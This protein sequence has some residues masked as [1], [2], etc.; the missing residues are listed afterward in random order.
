MADQAD[1]LIDQ[2]NAFVQ[3][4]TEASEEMRRIRDGVTAISITQR[5]TNGEVTVTVNKDGAVT[6]IEFGASASGLPPAGLSAVT[7]DTIRRATGRIGER[8]SGIVEQ[9]GLDRASADR[10]VANYRTRNPARFIEENPAV[11]RLVRRDDDDEENT[12]FME[13][14]Y[15]HRRG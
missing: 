12:S 10:I 11:P 14:G 9:S 13:T 7:M 1:A 3:D 6:A 4:A 15:G 8:Y 5:S 2:L